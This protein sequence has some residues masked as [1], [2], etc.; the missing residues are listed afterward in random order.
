MQNEFLVQDAER[1]KLKARIGLTGPTNSGKTYTAL[2]IAKGLL[3]GDHDNIDWSK[4]GIVDSE[5]KR[6]LFYANDGTFGKFKF[7]DLTPPYSPD[8]YKA[9]I[10]ALL[11]AGCEVIIIDSITHAWSGTGGVLDIVNQRTSNSSSK[12]SYKDGWGGVDGGSAQQNAL[13]DFIMSI[14]AHTICTFRSKMESVMEKDEGTGRTNIR[15]V[16]LKPIQRDD[17]EYEFDI[18]LDLDKD[19][20]SAHVTK[21]TVQSIDSKKA[22]LGPITEDFGKDLALYL[23]KGVDPETIKQAQ[24]Q[25][26]KEVIVSLVKDSPMNEAICKTILKDQK[27]KDINDLSLLNEIIRKIKGE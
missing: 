25:H 27:L 21:N 19:T 9:A 2:I 8:R 14:N 13:I 7:I 10:Q 11:N 22:D 16:G 4:V 5:R 3:Q 20:H 26:A 6:S 24:L 17:L 15:K 23:D 1:L 12:N 18:T